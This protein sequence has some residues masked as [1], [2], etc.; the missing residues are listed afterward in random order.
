[1]RYF[2]AW[3]LGMPFSVTVVWYLPGHAACGH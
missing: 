2:E 1:M 3:M